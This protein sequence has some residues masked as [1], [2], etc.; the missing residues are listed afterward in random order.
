MRCFGHLY[1]TFIVYMQI[2]MGGMVYCPKENRG[3]KHTSLP[4]PHDVK[5]TKDA[6]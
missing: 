3:I 2:K 4:A 6:T 5:F 1:F